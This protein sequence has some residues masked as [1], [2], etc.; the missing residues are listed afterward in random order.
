MRTIGLT[1]G[2]ACGKSNV[3]AEL[4]RLGAF[5]ID[6]DVL[7]RELQAPGGAALPALREAFGDGIFAADAPETLDRKALAALVFSDSAA[8]E[9][10]DAVMQ[11]LI[12]GEILRRME[13]ARARGERLCVLDMPLLY[14]KGLERLCDAV[15]CVSLPE[16]QQ[17]ERLMARDGIGREAALARIRSQLPA[18]EKARRADVV[19]D[20]SGS[21]GYTKSLVPPLVQQELAKEGSVLG[22]A[23]TAETHGAL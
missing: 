18:A 1:G 15:W 20:T 17:L 21:I 22:S 3:S 2:I 12:L 11:P 13:E 14:E 19:I 23:A 8:L 7:T 6:G 5:V 10:L 16:E 9:K 4:K